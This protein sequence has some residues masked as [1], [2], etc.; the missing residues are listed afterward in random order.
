MA[1]LA[2]CVKS[3]NFFRMTHVGFTRMTLFCDEN[4]V[5]YGFSVF[6]PCF[7]SYGIF[8]LHWKQLR[9]TSGAL[10]PTQHRK[11]LYIDN[12][13]RDTPDN[14]SRHTSVRRCIVE[15]YLAVYNDK[16][17]NLPFG[18]SNL[19][20]QIVFFYK[21]MQELYVFEPILTFSF[22][23]QVHSPISMVIYLR[24]WYYIYAWMNSRISSNTS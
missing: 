22:A 1:S 14:I 3:D 10:W 23:C 8:Q 18:L 7:L 2:S 20:K 16:L 15:K 9:G 21:T 5:H 6:Q 24:L 12:I 11:Y 19:A 13:S 17:N 4:I